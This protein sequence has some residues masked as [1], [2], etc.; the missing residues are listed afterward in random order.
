VTQ[1]G[2]GKLL[3]NAVA[4]SDVDIYSATDIELT[5]GMFA[6]WVG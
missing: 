6:R 2:N 3:K 5:T 1:D 4:G